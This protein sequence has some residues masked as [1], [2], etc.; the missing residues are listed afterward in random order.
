MVGGIARTVGI[1]LSAAIGGLAAV[2]VDLFQK[3][4]AS[5]VYELTTVVNSL[6]SIL[7]PS[8]HLSVPV[9]GVGLALMVFSILLAFISEARTRSAAFYSGAS[10]ITVL[11]TLVPY[12]APLPT[13]SGTTVSSET[14]MG[15][16]T[17]SDGFI[18]A[19][20]AGSGYGTFGDARVWFAQSGNEVPVTIIVNVP[21]DNAQAAKTTRITGL[22]HDALTGRKWQLGYAVPAGGGVNGVVTYRFDLQIEAG[23]PKSG[24]VADLN[25]RIEADGYRVA[26]VSQSVARVGEPVTLEVNLEPSRVPQAI[27]K[28]LQRPQF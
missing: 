26:T 21:T 2:L 16:E 14:A 17:W 15:V 24:L 20:Y 11:M 22:L 3:Q 28:L 4:D 5:A 6:A 23:Q 13:P 10:V 19:A 25:C 7:Q 9:V 27:Q 18:P 12:D 8:G 1:G